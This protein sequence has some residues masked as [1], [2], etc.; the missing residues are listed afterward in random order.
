MAK[1]RFYDEYGNQ[2]RSRPSRRL[3]KKWQFLVMAALGIV[4]GIIGVYVFGSEDKNLDESV[5]QEVGEE[6]NKI[7]ETVGEDSELQKS[8]DKVVEEQNYTYKDFEGTYVTFEGEPYNSPIGGDI[9]VLGTDFYQSINR[10]DFDMT[11]T[12]LYKTIDWNVLTLDLDSDKN[13]IW[14]SHSESGI[15]QFELRYDGDKKVLYSITNDHTFYSMSNQDLRTHYSQSEIDYA[16]I[17]MTIYGEP[18]LDQ[19]AVW[20][21]NWGIPVVNVSYNSVGD[22]TEVSNAVPYPKDVIHLNLTSLGMAAGI[23]TY[24]SHGNGYITRYPMPLH[25]HQEDQSEEGY[26]QLAQDA[27]DDAHTIY[28]E[29]FDPYTVADF[30]GRIEFVY[31]E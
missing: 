10:W 19:W 17:I 26:R 24:S 3:Y 30:I 16:R 4:F 7:D 28:V 29:P 22:P 23:I 27:L 31:K 2:V 20:N 11:S 8:E 15:E 14:G 21:D 5:E 9:I 6:A 18:S 12:I 1:K 25:Y 13:E